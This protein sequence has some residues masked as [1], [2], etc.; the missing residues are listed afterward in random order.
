MGHPSLDEQD[1]LAINGMMVLAKDVVW[2]D[3]TK[4]PVAQAKLLTRNSPS[5]CVGVA[6]A[7]LERI[8]S[9]IVHG[10][11]LNNV[12]RH[13]FTGLKWSDLPHIHRYVSVSDQSTADALIPLLLSIP[14]AVRGVSLEPM[15]GPVDLGLWLRPLCLDHVIVGGESGRKA[16][17]F[18]LEWA[19]DV[20]Y[21][22]RRAG[23]PCFVKQMGAKPY[24]SNVNLWDLED[25]IVEDDPYWLPEDL[26]SGCAV[27]FTGAGA[28][29]S[30]WPESLRVQQ[31]VGDP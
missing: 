21:R 26:A 27:K 2:Q 18:A 28:D 14:A 20:I 8:D 15:I 9:D 17:P 22:C 1:W 30:E 31:N 19:L 23:V 7:R 13:D 16:R 12:S 25:R 10:G 5:D 6:L 29:P 11:V 3:L 4:R 24:T